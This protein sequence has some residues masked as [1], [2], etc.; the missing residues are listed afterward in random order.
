MNLNPEKSL[1]EFNY[2]E[3]LIIARGSGGFEGAGQFY[4]LGYAQ[5][6]GALAHE[7]MVAQGVAGGDEG[8]QGVSQGLAALAERGLHYFLE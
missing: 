7:V 4:E 3:F 1:N 5:A 8:A 2:L 6:L